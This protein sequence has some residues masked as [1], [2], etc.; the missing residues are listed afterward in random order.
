MDARVLPQDEC[1]SMTM[2]ALPP[3]PPPVCLPSLPMLRRRQVR[4]A[5][6]PALT[7]S[8]STRVEPFAP[9]VDEME[10]EEEHRSLVY[11]SRTRRQRA[12]RGVFERDLHLSLVRVLFGALSLA[13]VLSDVLRAGLGLQHLGTTS[14]RFLP[15]TYM[16]SGPS[17]N[18]YAAFDRAKARN[19][20]VRVWLY[21]FDTMS[22]VWRAFGQHLDLQTFPR[23]LFYT[24][25]CASDL[26]NGSVVFDMMDSL[27]SGLAGPSTAGDSLEPVATLLRTES[28]FIDRFHQLLL[29]QLFTSKVWRVH[30]GLYY[31]PAA[32][33]R[34]A[35]APSRQLCYHRGPRPLFCRDTYINYRRSCKP[36]DAQC[37][38]VGVLHVD[39]LRSA[40][41]VQA[42]YRGL[43][44]DLTVLDSLDDAQVTRGGVATVGF[45]R[46]EVTTLV[47]ARNC[48]GRG[49]ATA[50]A[51][52][53]TVYISEH[54]YASARV[55]SD[56]DE[57]FFVVAVLRAAGQSYFFLRVLLLAGSCF[58]LQSLMVESQSSTAVS[59]APP[60]LPLGGRLRGALL[61]LAKVPVQCVVYGSSVPV[62]CY[63]LAHGIDSPATYLR[64][65]GAFL[66][67]G[68]LNSIRLASF[69]PLAVMQMRNVWLFALALHALVALH[70][71]RRWLAWSPMR[72]VLGVPEYL[73][74][75]V[76]C[77]TVSAQ[78]RA[79]SFRWTPITALLELAPTA[80]G[81]GTRLMAVKYLHVLRR[82]GA[83]HVQLG[84]V[85][86]DLKYLAVAAA[87]VV[88]VWA[89]VNL[90]SSLLGRRPWR[91]G[92]RTPAPYSAGILWPRAALAVHWSSD[93]FCIRRPHH[94]S[95]AG[96]TLDASV[97]VA[98][99]ASRLRR[100]VG[101]R[102]LAGD[103]ASPFMSARTF[104][105]IQRQMER[106]PE[107][108]D[109]VGPSVAFM[110]LVV[111]SDPLVAFYLRV[112]G[113]AVRLGYFRSRARPGAVHLL[114]ADV[115]THDNEYAGDLELL[116][117]AA[118]HELSWPEL[119]QCG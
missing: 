33:R 85:L 38:G 94:R 55:S 106:V 105:F 101:L 48:T 97:A 112:A 56:S 83:G 96:A 44:V 102:R 30:Q 19:T 80:D 17:N 3:P 27:A 45:R 66:S 41:A 67:S 78:Y 21:K 57:W 42:K 10:I 99:S 11:E 13:L 111:M 7:C 115:V 92:G 35:A 1:L 79:P 43:S 95:A 5:S 26:L 52:C 91:L 46:G 74:S 2:L 9:P 117:R 8:A 6:S 50:T 37:Q 82:R 88:A 75:G 86:I 65:N 87:A 20:T 4:P 22:L 61:L 114:P 110:N 14:H 62:L 63:S 51:K 28:V 29:P 18:S 53:E 72:G 16:F 109:E 81:G 58:W 103:A 31:S 39:I 68:G 15:S 60:R 32:L 25:P 113:A 69:V 70:S 24:E 98:V 100:L 76:S 116:L 108:G 71:T 40:A 90:V 118:S 23:C 12:M 49:S 59:T 54:R 84:G 89:A 119:L 36:K 104:D 93:F 47:R 107:R 77:L 34:Q 73:L 64:L